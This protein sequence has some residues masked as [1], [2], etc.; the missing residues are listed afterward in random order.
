MPNPDI[1]PPAVPDRAAVAR[2]IAAVAPLLATL[3]ARAD[4]ALLAHLL[5]LA[6]EES[7]VLAVDPRTMKGVQP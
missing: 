7:A 5:E 6:A 4:F 1:P 2:E 3:A